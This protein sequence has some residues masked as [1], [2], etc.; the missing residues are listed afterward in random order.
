MP[1][2]KLR[3][4]LRYRKPSCWLPL[5]SLGSS[6]LTQ[7]CSALHFE[8]KIENRRSPPLICSSSV[9]ALGPCLLLADF[10][11]EVGDERKQA[12]PRRR[13]EVLASTRSVGSGG[14]EATALT[15]ERNPTSPGAYA[16]A[17]TASGGGR[18]TSLASLRRFCA[19]AAS[20]NSN[21]APRGPRNRKR[22]SRRMRLRCANSISTRFL[23]RRDR[24]NASVF[25]VA[26]AT[27]RASS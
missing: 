22:P 19:I 3:F 12:P 13:S 7:P 24:S 20:M 26:R 16:T 8:F 23:S 1:P 6:L 18:A 2:H 4:L 9:A 17:A 27:S 21:W 15:L 14:F 10:V 5:S 11:A 25:A